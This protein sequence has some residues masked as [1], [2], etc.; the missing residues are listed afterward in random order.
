MNAKIVGDL[1]V[2]AGELPL[3]PLLPPNPPTPT[4]AC[5]SGT[6]T[7]F[8]PAYQRQPVS[9]VASCVSCSSKVILGISG[10]PPLLLGSYAS[11]QSKRF[12]ESRHQLMGWRLVCRLVCFLVEIDAAVKKDL[13]RAVFIYDYLH[14]WPSSI[15]K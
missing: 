11:Y 2:Y 12:A 3:T 5:T 7:S 8:F 1:H 13:A 14:A 10:F 4:R 6:D 9:H 15:L